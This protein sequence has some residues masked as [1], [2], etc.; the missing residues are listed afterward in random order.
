MCIDR[1]NG[2]MS[3]FLH[4][5]MFAVLFCGFPM[6]RLILCFQA[7]TVEQLEQKILQVC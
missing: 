6:L 1:T 4:L 7:G 5:I 2:F 3:S